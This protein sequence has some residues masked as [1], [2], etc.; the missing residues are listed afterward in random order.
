MHACTERPTPTQIATTLSKLFKKHFD[1]AH[2]TADQFYSEGHQARVGIDW[3][4]YRS[5]LEGWVP[6]STRGIG[7]EFQ[8]A[9]DCSA[10]YPGLWSETSS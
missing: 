7:V 1:T 5:Y 10:R 2:L 9:D 6:C 3:P 4:H 8:G